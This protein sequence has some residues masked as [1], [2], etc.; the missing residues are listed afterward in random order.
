MKSADSLRG[1]KQREKARGRL[2]EEREKAAMAARAINA[3]EL[4]DPPIPPQSA[5][6]TACHCQ[7]ALLKSPHLPRH[8]P[9]GRK[10]A[11]SGSGSGS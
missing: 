4:V 3:S 1:V 10:G 6:T 9:G 7:Y 8:P 5:I 11:G 2:I